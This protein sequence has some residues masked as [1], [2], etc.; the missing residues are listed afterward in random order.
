MMRVSI[1]SRTSSTM[2]QPLVPG[3]W[4][5]SIPCPLVSVA[6][7]SSANTAAGLSCIYM[8]LEPFD[9]SSAE[10]EGSR[11][12]LLNETSHQPGSQHN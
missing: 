4:M 8:V 12:D 5:L 10:C 6:S 2:V 3:T 1:L 11:S 9:Q 7:V